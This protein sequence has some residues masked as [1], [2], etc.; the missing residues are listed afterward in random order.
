MFQGLKN[1]WYGPI[2]ATEPNSAE[3]NIGPAQVSITDVQG[4]VVAGERRFE[5][6]RKERQDPHSLRVASW[7][8][9]GDQVLYPLKLADIQDHEWER[10]RIMVGVIPRRT[11]PAADSLDLHENA[12]VEMT[13]ASGSAWLRTRTFA[14]DRSLVDGVR[15]EMLGAL[16]AGAR[17]I[18]PRWRWA[19]VEFA[20][21][22]SLLAGLWLWTML[23][24][25]PAVPVWLLSGAVVATCI[26]GHLG[27]SRPRRQ[28]PGF[29]TF[30]GSVR[31][32]LTPRR[33]VE[34]DRLNRHRDARVALIYGIAG[35]L[36]GALGTK[37]LGL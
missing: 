13:L 28:R 29:G 2:T 27:W 20:A 8:V 30:W 21:V 5:S 7:A 11:S 36:L 16:T 34:A 6:L 10:A 19:R 23:S 18:T 33:Q 15:R 25:Q 31:V 4:A 14:W 3:V 22:A 12:G 26:G 9:I 37:L 24:T 32:D 17:P 35:T 1:Y